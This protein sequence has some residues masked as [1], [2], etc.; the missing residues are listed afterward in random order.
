VLRKIDFDGEPPKI[1]WI[2]DGVCARGYLTVLAGD[3]GMGKSWLALGL[4]KGVAEG[5]SIAGIPCEK[6]TV[7]Y[8][9]AENGQLEMHRRVRALGLNGE[10]S[11]YLA[12]G[13]NL[14]TN[15]PG[16]AHY[17]ATEQP[18]LLILDGLRSLWP[19]GDENDSARVTGILDPLREMLREYDVGCIL[20]H[21]LN[22]TG[23]YRGSGA[24]KAC[25]EI[26]INMYARNN[27]NI[28]L[29]KWE[30]CRIGNMPSHKH[31]FQIVNGP[32]G[33]VM[34]DSTTQV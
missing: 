10:C 27:T 22:K 14:G 5:R 19:D 9:D 15:Q 28:R 17:L 26:L 29:L 7:M 32:F 1:P 8:V 31:E 30:K 21:H 12:E 6:G 33:G 18:S 16:L 2:C 24:I 25:P 11:V 13:F 23:G 3:A 20:L 4:G 34:L